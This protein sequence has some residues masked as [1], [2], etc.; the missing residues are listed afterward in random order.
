MCLRSTSIV[1]Y[2]LL[3]SILVIRGL[4]LKKV[5]VCFDTSAFDRGNPPKKGKSFFPENTIRMKEKAFFYVL[6]SFKKRR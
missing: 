1:G 5:S 6:G 3:N 4:V 2:A